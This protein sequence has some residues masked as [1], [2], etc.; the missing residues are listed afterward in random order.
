MNPGAEQETVFLKLD[1]KNAFN[2]IRRDTA[3][4][5]IAENM[6]SLLPFFKVCYEESSFLNFGEDL[7]LSEEGFQ[8]GDP[9]AVFGFCL[10]IH[11]ILKEIK[12]RFK[13]GYI[14]D[15]S[16]GDYWRIVLA[17]LQQL[18]E[19]IRSLGLELN[20]GKSELTIFCDDPEKKKFILDQFLQ[21][22]PSI[23]V[24]EKEDLLLLG[25]PLGEQSAAIELNE[26]LEALEL[27]TQRVQHVKSHEAFF[28]LRNCLMIPKLLYLLRT[29]PV[30]SS[31]D[32][33]KYD[34]LIRCALSKVTNVKMT[35]AAWIQAGL[36][37]KMGGLG[38][39]RPSQLASSAFLSSFHSTTNLSTEIFKEFQDDNTYKDAFANWQNLSHAPAPLFPNKQRSWF[40]PVAKRS[41]LDLQDSALDIDK[42]RLQGVLCPGASDWL[43]ALPS[44]TLCLNLNDAQFRI[45]VGL[46]LGA[47][48]CS[49]HTC[50]CGSEVDKFGQHALVCSKSRSIHARHSLGNNVIFRG[51]TA[52]Q[53][54][55]S[56]EPLGLFRNG[57]GK[58]P[59]GVTLV[60][61]DHG[62][63]LA[64]DLTVVHRL[65]SSYMRLA[66]R[67]GPTI[68]DQ[69]ED[70][71]RAK[72]SEITASHE[73]QPIAIETLG[74]LGT[75]T[76]D[77]LKTL[78]TRIS[79]VTDEK[80]ATEFLRQRL[81][82]AIQIGN[83][84]IV[85]ENLPA[86]VDPLGIDF[87]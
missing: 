25:A 22:C 50:M 6:P 85:M 73:M 17:D 8:Q 14:D 28:L 37:C 71:K 16:A 75:T 33:E 57:D 10:S 30:F 11:K 76:L 86:R 12:S 59:D 62:K 69:A 47:P 56:L 7:I 5:I 26:K 24:T 31:A 19:S 1:F 39:I 20:E 41:L 61:W 3:A 45:A 78:G 43:N 67:E 36:P 35:D 42:A 77:F 27:L 21:V 18:L 80:R 9:A 63:P 79:R 72:Y 64:W 2:S 52:A 15:I 58:R 68:A 55:S 87:D 32:L 82:I 53:L 84:A 54:P 38:T 60:P 70:K 29:S 4:E 34:N 48:V 40:T 44:R 66:R 81:A 49:P 51:L 74:G 23:A 13:L 65:A 46:R 83:A